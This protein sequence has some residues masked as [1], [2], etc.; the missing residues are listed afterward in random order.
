MRTE[1]GAFPLYLALLLAIAA[2]AMSTPD[3]RTDIN[4]TA[5]KLFAVDLSGFSNAD[6]L[7]AVPMG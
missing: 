5:E 7:E 4:R 6:Y 3:L 1:A 2:A